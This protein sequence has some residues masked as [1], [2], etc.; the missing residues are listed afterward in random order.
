VLT[1]YVY[2]SAHRLTRVR[3]DLTPENAAD[4]VFFDT[5]YTDDG[6]S[7]R[8][9]SLT[10]ADG[11]TVSFTYEQGLDFGSGDADLY[12]R[13]GALPALDTFDAKA[14]A[15]AGNVELAYLQN[16]A[17][18]VWYVGGVWLRRGGGPHA[19]RAAHRIFQ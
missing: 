4:A 1:S 14:D 15:S 11:A 19:T 6:A 18:G 3:V 10:P 16:P 17:A 7:T 2:D 9:A 5:T 13:R 12:V 8:I